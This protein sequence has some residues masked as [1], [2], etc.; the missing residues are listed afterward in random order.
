MLFNVIFSFNYHFR[1]TVLSEIAVIIA[2]ILLLHLCVFHIYINYLGITTYGYVRAQRLNMEKIA[3]EMSSQT[4][5]SQVESIEGQENYQLAVNGPS[6]QLNKD[7]GDAKMMDKIR[8]CPQQCQRLCVRVQIEP[9]PK[10]YKQNHTIPEEIDQSDINT[11]SGS[12]NSNGVYHHNDRSYTPDRVIEELPVVS[13][14]PRL[15]LIR[16]NN[17]PN[18]TSPRP[19]KD[20]HKVRRHLDQIGERRDEISVSNHN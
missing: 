9:V 17:P 8:Q 20:I 12:L 2:L 19:T 7:E 16:T 5:D 3:K 14:I 10:Q 6:S 13:S 1:I 18:W 4:K 11:V 15:P